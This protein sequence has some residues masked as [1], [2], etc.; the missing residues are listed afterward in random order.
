MNFPRGLPAALIGAAA[1]IALVQPQMAEALEPSEIS[2]RAKEITVRI[3][4]PESGSGV[5]F[6]RTGTT[7][8]VLTNWHV[9]DTEGQYQITAPDGQNYAVAYSQVKYLPDVDL[10]VLQ[11][12]SNQS[13]PTAQLGNSD[14]MTEGKAVYVA[15]WSDPFAGIPERS[16]L[17]LEARI[18]SRLPKSEKGYAIV[19][20]N[21]ATPGTSGGPVLDSNA[22]LVGINGRFTSE[23]NTGKA[24][25]L[26]IPLQIFLAARNNLVP[27]AGI[28]PPEDFVSRGQR[29]ANAGNYRGAIAEYNKALESNANNF[30][31]YYRRGEAYYW[32][33]DFQ[34]AIADFDRV[35]RLNSNNALAYHWR[36][37]VRAEL[38]D[39]QA[40]LSD[41]NEAIRL[42]P[43]DAAAHNNRGLAR[44]YLRD[45]Q[46]AI[47]DYSEAILLNPNYPEAY[48]NRGNARFNLGDN[49]AAISD[50]NDSLRLKNPEPWI[51][52]NNRGNARANQGDNQAAISDYNEA[53][54]L[55]PN[56]AEA[57]NSR[58][59]ARLNQGDN[60]AAIS[61]Y[62]SAIRL[63]P[64]YAEAYNNR[65]NARFKQGD[66]Q[67]AISDY[68]ESLRRKNPEP[69][70]VYNNRGNARRNQ[71]DYQGAIYDY[72]EAIY[73]NPNYAVAY[74]RRGFTYRL[75]GDKQ[76]AIA[77]LQKAADLYW[78]Q[79]KKEDYQYALDRIRELLR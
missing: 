17:F 19:H 42:N 49:Q 9:V 15:G 28:A 43:N 46:A 48:N 20:D 63:N 47:S 54:R 3:D 30:E 32:L 64:N 68:N 27:P 62:N 69:W 11:F 65:G 39:Y 60:Q 35:L 8:S 4:G 21:P 79:G 33:K 18:T 66:Y 7:Y 40:A 58:G 56:Y 75:L 13:Y 37:F 31:A 59:I 1:T 38:K 71:G 2:A 74:D 78:Q 51:V 61:D 73:L 12:T 76:R 52:Y 70:I 72:N 23:P 77:D 34:A 5:I 50:F 22:R 44:F 45:Y 14:E 26:S 16:Y 55:N 53:I 24:F 29:L 36:G 67:A 6:E 25:G 57:Y 41:Y 10:A